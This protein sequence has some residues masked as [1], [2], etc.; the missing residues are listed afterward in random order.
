MKSNLIITVFAFLFLALG[1]SYAQCP[2]F[3]KKIAAE[4][5]KGYQLE[6]KLSTVNLNE[7]QSK[8]L[9]KKFDAG[10]KYKVIIAAEGNLEK[11]VFQVLDIGREV[12]FDGK[13]N[14]QKLIVWEITPKTTQHL[15]LRVQAPKTS[16]GKKGCVAVLIGFSQP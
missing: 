10:K 9:F 12:I 1:S 3:A 6:A 8:E 15:T 7:G 16:G 14:E 5:L 13:Q 4:Q 2:E 11:L